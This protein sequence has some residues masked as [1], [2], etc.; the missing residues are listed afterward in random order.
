M[1]FP[2]AVLVWSGLTLI[3]CVHQGHCSQP[4]YKL[5]LSEGQTLT[6]G[7]SKSLPWLQKK[8]LSFLEGSGL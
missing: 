8:A 4:V 5:S 7:A 2:K 6:V 1:T 3:L